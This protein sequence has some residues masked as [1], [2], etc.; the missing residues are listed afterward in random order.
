MIQQEYWKEVST[1]KAKEIIETVENLKPLYTS[2]SLH[3]YEERY[4]IEGDIF[5][6]FYYSGE[7]PFVQQLI[8]PVL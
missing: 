5:G 3:I 8:K 1:E 6:L 4:E 2:N 7:E